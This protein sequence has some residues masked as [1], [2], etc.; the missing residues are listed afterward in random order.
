[1]NLLSGKL[2]L[3][4]VARIDVYLHVLF[5]ILLAWRLLTSKD[6]DSLRWNCIVLAILFVSILLHEFGHCFGARAIGGDADEILMWPLGGLAFLHHPRTPWASFVA[7]AA[8]P[9]VNLVL[10]VAGYGIHSA[11]SKPIALD[12][13]WWTY[14]GIAALY[15]TNLFLLIFNVIP[16][17][18]M[19]GGRLFQ[20]ILWP[21]IGYKR[22]L[23][24]TIYLAFACGTGMVVLGLA[25]FAK[26]QLPELAGIGLFVLLSS[27]QE[28]Q[29]LHAEEAADA[30][31]PWRQSLDPALELDSGPGP[32]QRFLDRRAVS[33]R[34]KA[35]EDDKK[36]A[37][38]LDVVLKRVS[39]V[40]MN[41]LTPEER[42][43]L[44]EE[45]ARRRKKP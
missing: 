36:R 13:Y 38:R 12:G 45:S 14:H 2:K 15:G 22:S 28:L 29:R 17:F 27:W 10:G 9:A 31:E 4:R 41:G 37:E 1:V 39:E 21:W 35:E 6:V 26:D 18:P 30:A 20:T 19:D 5:L 24:I 40:G 33:K 34:L 42:T 44:E 23:R 16:A 43:F 8:G 25:Q 3:F 11:L 32:I 7:T